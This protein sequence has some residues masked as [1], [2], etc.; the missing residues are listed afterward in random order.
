MGLV[1]AGSWTGS[2]NELGEQQLRPEDEA[3]QLCERRGRRA[4]SLVPGTLE[5]CTA[6]LR[7]PSEDRLGIARDN[8]GGDGSTWPAVPSPTRTV[9]A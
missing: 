4:A 8:H 5:A 1:M 9:H 6:A 3:A 2:G 7:A